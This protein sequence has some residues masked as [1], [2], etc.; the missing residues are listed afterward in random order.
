MHASATWRRPWGPPYSAPRPSA[1]SASVPAPG[2]L[3]AALAD[4]G[5]DRHHDEQQ[6][7]GQ[8]AAAERP[9]DEGPEA[10]ARDHQRLAQLLLHQLAQHEAQQQGRRLE[11]ELDE[12]IAEEAEA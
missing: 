1:R 12:R 4:G 2:P 10:A 3:V 6:R 8:Q 7:Q 11:A 9:I 5:E